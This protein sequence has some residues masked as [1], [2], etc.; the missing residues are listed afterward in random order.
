MLV[1]GTGKGMV[2][3]FSLLFTPQKPVVFL[4]RKYLFAP[5]NHSIQNCCC[6]S[7][8]LSIY[9]LYMHAYVLLSSPISPGTCTDPDAR[10][11][12]SP[13]SHVLLSNFLD[14]VRSRIAHTMFV[15]MTRY[16][17]FLLLDCLVIYFA[18]HVHG[19]RRTCA[20]HR[21]RM[22]SS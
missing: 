10:V 18:R 21:R 12:F 14:Q 15:F 11:Y 1:W 17:T 9:M 5:E 4:C 19:S 3:I 6:S 8:H 22:Y 13:P 7:E 2:R 20:S 16:R